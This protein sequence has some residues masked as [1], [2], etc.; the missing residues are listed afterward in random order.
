M[1]LALIATMLMGGLSAAQPTFANDPYYWNWWRPYY[2]S[3]WCSST[4]LEYDVGYSINAPA[5]GG[6]QIA[7]EYLNGTFIGSASTSVPPGH[8]GDVISTGEGFSPPLAYPYTY[9]LINIMYISTGAT[10]RTTTTVTCSGPGLVN[11]SI[12]NQDVQ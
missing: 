8:S 7:Y 2:H 5:S 9:K 6:T 11:I 4:F 12:V 10:S 1:K 3:E